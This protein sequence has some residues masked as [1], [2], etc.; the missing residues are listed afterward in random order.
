MSTE[1]FKFNAK[2]G[3]PGFR[4]LKKNQYGHTV[5]GLEDDIANDVN[6]NVAFSLD[7]E[8]AH[9]AD[10]SIWDTQPMKDLAEKF[11]M[12]LDND[13]DDAPN[14][15]VEPADNGHLTNGITAQDMD[16]LLDVIS[17]DSDTD[18]DTPSVAHFNQSQPDLAPSDNRIRK[19]SKNSSD[20]SNSKDG[21]PCTDNE[22]G[23]M[24]PD[25]AKFCSTCGKLQKINLFCIECG[26]KFNDREKF[27]ADCGC[28]RD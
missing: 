27:C 8:G 9:R 25:G 4:T 5:L 19:V 16:D 6:K 28:A 20:S 12:P 23:A 17:N 24:L 13:G 22:C 3:E 2:P 21:K 18:N 11:N 10:I 15:I 1:R 26:R 14:D 7:Q